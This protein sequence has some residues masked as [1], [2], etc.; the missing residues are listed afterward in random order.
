MIVTIQ[1]ATRVSE[2]ERERAALALRLALAPFQ[3]RV[4]RASLR[5]GRGRG[6]GAGEDSLVQVSVTLRPTGLLRVGARGTGER[7]CTEV[8]IQRAAT[9]IARRLSLEQQELLELL[10][11]T[12]YQ[13]RGRPVDAR[14]AQRRGGMPVGALEKHG[15]GRLGG[16]SRR[17]GARAAA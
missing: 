13:V 4:A 3:A 1:A 5:A 15:A 11:L 14:R 9:A 17:R 10:L 2:L 6:V 12:S 8:A 16:A 7:S